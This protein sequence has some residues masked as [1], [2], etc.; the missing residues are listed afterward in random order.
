MAIFSLPKNFKPNL[1]LTIGALATL[2]RVPHGPSKNPPVLV[3]HQGQAVGSTVASTHASR[4]KHT[5]QPDRDGSF[6]DSGRNA[7]QDR[8]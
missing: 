7:G 5:Q 4:W 3:K 6:H 2:K 1:H 8:G